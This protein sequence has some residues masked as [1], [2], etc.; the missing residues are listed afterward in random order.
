MC[1]ENA[2]ELIIFG[3]PLNNVRKMLLDDKAGKATD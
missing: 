1:R 2:L 3:I